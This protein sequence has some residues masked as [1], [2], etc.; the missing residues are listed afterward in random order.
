MDDTRILTKMYGLLRLFLMMAEPGVAGSGVREYQRSLIANLLIWEWYEQQ[1]HP[2]MELAQRNASLFNEESGEISFSAL[3]RQVVGKPSQSNLD[4][5]HK[6]YRL[7]GLA[8]EVCRDMDVQFAAGLG[9]AEGEGG[10]PA[11]LL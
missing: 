5:I 2:V 10:L 6:R 7:I 4:L 11:S 8:M 9:G 1:G 3:A